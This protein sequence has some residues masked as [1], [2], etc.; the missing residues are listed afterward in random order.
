[1]HD[2]APWRFRGACP[3]P[4]RARRLAA[5]T[6]FR[7]YATPDAGALALG[8]FGLRWDS[9]GGFGAHPLNGGRLQLR[10]S[11]RLAGASCDGE[12]RTRTG[13]DGVPG[14]GTDADTTGDGE[15][16]TRTGDT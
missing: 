9:R 6:P 3:A 8:D 1:M 5:W 11:G 13:P 15:T 16:R 14:R 12:T 7:D 4:P 10:R 2:A